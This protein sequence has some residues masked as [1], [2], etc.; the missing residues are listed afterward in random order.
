MDSCSVIGLSSVLRLVVTVSLIG[1]PLSA[2]EK[3]DLRPHSGLTID[4]RP[5]SQ[6]VGVTG[7]VGRPYSMDSLS[8]QPEGH[9]DGGTPEAQEVVNSFAA[10]Q[11][12]L[13]VGQEVQVRTEAGQATQGRVVSISADQLV[14]ARPLGRATGLWARWFSRTEEQA[15][16]EAAVRRIRAVS[17]PL[18]QPDSAF[19]VAPQA[20]DERG[21][22]IVT[23]GL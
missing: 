23:D 20:G 12:V 2:Q 8:E 21:R 22:A 6:L 15:F 3:L 17:T 19:T 11:P 16:A 9:I 7:R 13:N 18:R 5:L 1:T 4:G 10:L 14:I